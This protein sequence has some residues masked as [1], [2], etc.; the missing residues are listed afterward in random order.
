[1]TNSTQNPRNVIFNGDCIDVMR[2]FD[3]ASVDFIL[4]DPPYVTNFRDR[5][6]RTV[7][8]DDNGRWLRPAFNQMHRVLKDG[9]FCVSFYGWNKVDLF[10]D[11][12]KAAGFRVVGHLV[13]RKRYASSTRF[14]RYEHEQAYLLAKG[15]PTLPA[16]PIPDVLDFPYTGNR[17]HPTQ[18]PVEALT[19]L[20]EGFTKPGDLVLDPF[21]GSGSTLAAAQQTGRNWTGIELDNAHYHTARKRLA[22]LQRHRVAA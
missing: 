6:G 19:P 21:S 2:S 13:F 17:L 14:L 12:W 22:E 18:K 8:N 4:T 16:Q 9:G 10:M 20:I 1:M 5:Q 15:N 11:A 7:A 3:R